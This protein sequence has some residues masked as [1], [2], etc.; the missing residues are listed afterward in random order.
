MPLQLGFHFVL[1]NDGA[2]WRAMERLVSEVCT[3]SDVR[4]TTYSDYLDRLDGEA[5]HAS[6]NKS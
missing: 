3:R 4:C 5:L 1:M 2:Y 6:Q